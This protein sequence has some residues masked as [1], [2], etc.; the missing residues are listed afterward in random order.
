M[1]MEESMIS[2]GE[3]SISKKKRHSK[4]NKEETVDDLIAKLE[5]RGKKVVVKDEGESD[6][7]SF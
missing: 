2:N 4:T 7:E 3:K 5:A 1:D 6:E